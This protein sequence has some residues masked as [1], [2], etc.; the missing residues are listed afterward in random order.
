MARDI[1]TEE[2]VLTHLKDVFNLVKLFL[3]VAQQILFVIFSFELKLL[4]LD[5]HRIDVF[6]VFKPL[7]LCQCYLFIL[8][9]DRVD[10]IR[11]GSLFAV[12]ALR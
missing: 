4:L 12:N 3:R 8:I 7:L 1:G 5:E 2:G 11:P 9:V 6:A 10:H